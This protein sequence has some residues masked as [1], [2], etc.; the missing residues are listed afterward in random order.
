MHAAYIIC[1]LDSIAFEGPMISTKQSHTSIQFQRMSFPSAWLVWEQRACTLPKTLQEGD[2]AQTAAVL[3]P[4][5]T[6][7]PW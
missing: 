7:V 5:Y 4:V 2:T 6:T 1:Q 3:V